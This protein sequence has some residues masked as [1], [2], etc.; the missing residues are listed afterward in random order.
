[1]ELFLCFLLIIGQQLQLLEARDA[2]CNAGYFCQF[3]DS[4]GYNGR[5]R[6]SQS[7]YM[8]NGQVVNHGEFPSFAIV[9]AGEGDFRSICGGIILSDLHIATAASCFSGESA[10]SSV[11][12]NDIV[13]IVGAQ[14][15]TITDEPTELLL[16][17][18][19]FQV[20]EACTHPSFRANDPASG[21]DIGLLKLA[22]RL[23]FN[24]HIQPAC[25]DHV[26]KLR[27][28]GN[29]HQIGAGPSRIGY[30]D[31]KIRKML[32]APRRCSNNQN[33]FWGDLCM[34]GIRRDGGA[35][36]CFG[37]L[38]GPLVCQLRGENRWTAMGVMTG[39]MTLV[40]FK[41]SDQRETCQKGSNYYVTTFDDDFI[42]LSTGRCGP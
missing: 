18:G 15:N 16:S 9:V 6:K 42:S 27:H 28:Y 10:A 25:L 19:A 40:P 24:K 7:G 34:G 22:R 29:C 33:V 8:I 17:K 39:G 36:P 3:Q 4:C 41:Q 5:A 38:G 20:K 1:M 35:S 21:R 12:P 26:S 13:V 37:D 23:K 2:E 11:P 32:V 31:G 30:L 14:D